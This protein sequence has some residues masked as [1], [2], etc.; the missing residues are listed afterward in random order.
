[1][2]L[3]VI[4]PLFS[5]VLVINI[6]SRLFCVSLMESLMCSIDVCNEEAELVSVP[7]TII[8]VYQQLVKVLEQ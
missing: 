1:M 8:E 4:S 7:I 5:T 3:N 6:H 2:F